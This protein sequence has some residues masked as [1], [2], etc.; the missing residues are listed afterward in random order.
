MERTE[1]QMKILEVGKKEFLEKGFKGASLNKIVAEAGF[2]KG[3]FYGY[4]PDKAALFEDLVGEAAKGLLEQFKAAQSAHFDLISEEKTKDS[5][6]LSTEY[7]RVFVEYMYAHFDAFKLILCRAEGTRYANFLE[8]LVELEV[9]CA[10]EYYAL[11]RKR[12]KLSGKMTKQLPAP[13]LRRYVRRLPMICP[14]K[15]L[16]GMLRSLQGFSTLAGKACSGWNNAQSH[17]HFNF[18]HAS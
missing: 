2:T 18:L 1:T 10:E 3:A 9:E 6:K 4:Y 14:K 15:K 17:Q 7:L 8:E 11:L 16:C 12:G 5:L 13:I